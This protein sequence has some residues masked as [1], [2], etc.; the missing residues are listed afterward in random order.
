MNSF[1][2]KEN[3]L[4]DMNEEAEIEDQS[5]R[6]DKHGHRRHLDSKLKPQQPTVAPATI[7]P[8]ESYQISD[9]THK[10]RHT[11]DPSNFPQTW[12]SL[13]PAPFPADAQ[14]FNFFSPPFLNSATNFTYIIISS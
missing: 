5:H 4:K 14:Q 9:L 3:E 8:T 13:R 7:E 11:D 12:P 2:R 6:N 1:Q 10:G